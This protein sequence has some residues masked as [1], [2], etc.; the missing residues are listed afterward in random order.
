[1]TVPYQ[2]WQQSPTQ[3]LHGEIYAYS[4]FNSMIDSLLRP[5]SHAAV[6]LLRSQFAGYLHLVE[7]T[8]EDEGLANFLAVE[9]VSL[10]PD[11][12][13]PCFCMASPLLDGL[14][15]DH[16]IHAKFRSAPL[17]APPT[18]DNDEA[19]NVL[20]VLTESLKFFDKDLIRLAAS[21]A[22]KT[23]SVNIRGSSN[24]RVPRESVYNTELMRILSNWLQGEHGWTVT[25]HWHLENDRNQDRCHDIVIKKPDHPTV[26]LGLLATGDRH[27]I[28]SHNRED[29][30]E[31]GPSFSG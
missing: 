7:V 27:I 3:K 30:R 28:Q 1:M 2:K 25:G 21:R 16:V 12:A 26:I 11:I 17:V 31:Y 14:I 24:R 18:Q 29:A 23:P 19:L 20:D 4:T 13:E 9:G 6:I 15:R 10:R 22:Y 8:Q 5:E